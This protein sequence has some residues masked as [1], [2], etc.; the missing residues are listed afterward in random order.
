MSL[1]RQFVWRQEKTTQAMIR[2]DVAS[3]EMRD[4]LPKC[5]PRAVVAP[6]HAV[7][8]DLVIVDSVIDGLGYDKFQCS[9]LVFHSRRHIV[10]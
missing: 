7:Q 3:R 8:R 1:A 5:R 6:L 4:R 9:L 10:I 2:E